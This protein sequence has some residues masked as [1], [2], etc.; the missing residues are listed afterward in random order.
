MLN[1]LRVC[2][3]VYKS[4]ISQLQEKL[5]LVL[6]ETPPKEEMSPL[7]EPFRGKE[8]KSASK[9]QVGLQVSLK[10]GQSSI[11][12]GSPLLQREGNQSLKLVKE[13]VEK[14]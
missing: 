10:E 13:E 9:Q 14:K 4:Q 1:T 3:I 5:S 12:R 7:K 6:E 11:Y 2:Y 8:V